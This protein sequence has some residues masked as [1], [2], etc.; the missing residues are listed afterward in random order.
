M[1]AFNGTRNFTEWTT[2]ELNL[3][4][5][6]YISYHNA[7][8]TFVGGE[9]NSTSEEGQMANNST[10]GESH[11]NVD[12][13][14]EGAD[15]QTRDAFSQFHMAIMEIMPI[16]AFEEMLDNA[17]IWNSTFEGAEITTVLNDLQTKHVLY[18]TYAF[19]E[20]FFGTD[21]LFTRQGETTPEQPQES[22][23]GEG[24]TTETPTTE[25]SGR[26][27]LQEETP[28][29]EAAPVEEGTAPVEGGST[30]VPVEGT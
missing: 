21:G 19:F 27:F 6:Y 4:I 8:I 26:R 17:T 11:N 30:E 28:I 1:K 10:S 9:G 22:T 3:W 2:D 16:T 24:A 7:V 25:G 13:I 5:N 29:E 15:T 18:E 20:L 23:E 12:T 14:L